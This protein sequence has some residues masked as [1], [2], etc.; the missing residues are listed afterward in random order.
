MHEMAMLLCVVVAVAALG[1]PAAGNHLAQPGADGDA[2]IVLDDAILIVN[3]VEP[4]YVRHAVRNLREVVRGLSG[5]APRTA[6]R[7]DGSAPTVLLVGSAATDRLRGGALPDAGLGDEGYVLRSWREGRRTFVAAAGHT[8]RGS[9]L[10]VI[11]LLQQVRLLGGSAAIAGPLHERVK[12]AFAVRGMHL[13]G[14]A[15]RRPYSFR[16]WTESD[17]RRYIDMLGWQGVNLFYIWPFMEIIPLPLSAEDEKYLRE[18]RRVVDYAQTRHGMHVWLMQS[19][20]R[21]ARDNCGVP[22]PRKRPYWRPSQE[23]RNPADPQQFQA[24]MDSREA[25]YR[26]VDNVDGVC[27]IDADP[28]GW[29]DSPL[30]DFLKIL[31]GCREL[32]DRHN[33][34]GTRAKIICW[35]WFGWG[36]HG[37]RIADPEFMRETIRAM[38]AEMP[39][40]W[41][42]VAGMPA[43]LNVCREEGVLD[44]TVYLPYNTIEGEPSYPGTNVGFAESERILAHAAGTAGLAG[45]MGNAQCPLLQLPRVYHYLAALWDPR[46]LVRKET[47]TLRELGA[48][49]YPRHADLVADAYAALAGGDADRAEALARALADLAD[50]GRLGPPGYLGRCVFP[51]PAFV[52]RSLCLQ[53]RLAAAAA[54]LSESVRPGV[55]RDD[56][57]GL[58][59]NLLEAYLAWDTAHG[60]H[61]LWGRG[62]W[63]LGRLES[64]PRFRAAMRALKNAL[65]DEPSVTEFFAAVRKRLVRRFPAECVDGDAVGPLKQRVLAAIVVEPNLAQEAEATASV[66]PNPDR[67]PARHA[68]DGDIDTLYWPGALVSNNEE[69]LQLNWKSPRTVSVVVAYFLRHGSMWDR[70]IRLQA[71]GADGAWRDAAACRPVDTG[72][73]AVAR[74]PL[75]NPITADRLR[76]VNLLDLFEVE[77]R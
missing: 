9:R 38:K 65:G 61:E 43:Y 59:E 63:P 70:T 77:V 72:A 48:A 66:A 21:V 2:D 58:V 16:S 8:P 26:I 1:I 51:A 44:R 17:W 11:G 75:D 69:W 32:L 73:F 36:M 64:E 68:N 37:D 53:L 52:A 25:L 74:F 40:P 31:K 71:Q 15:F 23:D 39:E 12:P 56:C 4:L 19:A 5:R 60:W 20:N 76:I 29:Q 35:M 30:S 67:Y 41:M 14:W 47:E 10:A 49:L 24:I 54:R 18:V 62:S 42:L 22:D 45:V 7:D 13:N 50:S 33:M 28:G 55:S 27:T 57:A 34:H 46:T 6:S 3:R